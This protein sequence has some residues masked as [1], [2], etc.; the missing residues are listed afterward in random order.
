VTPRIHPRGQSFKGACAYILHD[1]DNAKTA[2]RVSFVMT[3]NLATKAPEWAW[4][5]MTE[6]YW[7]RDALKIA[8]GRDLRG[9][10][11]TRPVLH[12]SLSWPEGNQPTPEHM[13]DM[14]LSS[15]KAIGLGEHEAL[16]AGHDDKKHLHVHILVNTVHPQT[17]ITAPLNYT[18]DKFSKWAEA[19]EREHGIYCHER[20]K[21][22]AERARLAD[23]RKREAAELLMGKKLDPSGVLMAASQAKQQGKAPYV[24]VKH[25]A[26]S[27]KEWFDRKEIVDRMKA[28]RKEL[29]AE[30][31]AA[32]GQTWQHQMKER[33][34]LD[35]QTEAV[36]AEAMQKVKDHYRPYWRT[37][38]QVQRREASHLRKVIAYEAKQQAGK[39][40]SPKAALDAIN[41]PVDRIGDLNRDH[42]EARRTLVRQQRADAK[43]YSDHIMEW[44]KEQF[45]ELKDRQQLERQQQAAALA[46]QTK[47]ITFQA[48]K[49]SLQA[50]RAAGE[51]RPFKRAKKDEHENQPTHEQRLNR[52]TEQAQAKQE[53][54]RSAKPDG[55]TPVSRSE[56]IKR[57]MA[58]WRKRNDGKDLGR[59]M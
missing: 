57:D 17:G 5:E 28:M 42:E 13:M 23:E 20:I 7:A 58:E 49:A 50:E 15:L 47:E 26:V 16:I 56:Q 18:K 1:P 39:K 41:R 25:K 19:Y 48:A 11:N 14:A 2:D 32:K 55:A 33:D 6:T 22:N 53:F 31:K 10:K 54:E 35:A 38:Y 40:P 12:Y 51:D 46:P 30:I 3:A 59:E 44:H 21:N 4:H 37:L 36:M 34:A 45:N 43:M 8:A 9:Q 24:P 52:P 29:D 27:R